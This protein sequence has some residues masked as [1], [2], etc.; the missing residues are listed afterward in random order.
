[1]EDPR[2]AL[3][4]LRMVIVSGPAVGC[5]RSHLNEL[6]PLEAASMDRGGSL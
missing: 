3:L 1:M 6:L 2:G 4:L 5:S